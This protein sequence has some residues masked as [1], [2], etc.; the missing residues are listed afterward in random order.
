M[1]STAPPSIGLSITAREL[2]LVAPTCA[3]SGCSGHLSPVDMEVEE[4][5]EDGFVFVTKDGPL[6][7]FRHLAPPEHLGEIDNAIEK[8]G[9]I[10]WPLNSF[11]HKNPE[12]AF[13]EYKAHKELTRFM[14]SQEGWKVTESAYGM[15]TAWVAAYDSG[16]LGP[17]VS[18]NAEMGT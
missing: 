17:V 8:L 14:R 1:A 18:F 12:L 15:R 16:K 4:L 9:D 5:E 2:P 13:K 6:G 3:S 11:I 10:L 7:D